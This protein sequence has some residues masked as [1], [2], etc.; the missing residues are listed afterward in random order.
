MSKDAERPRLDGSRVRLMQRDGVEVGVV[1]SFEHL[2]RRGCFRRLGRC[3]RL[4]TDMSTDHVGGPAFGLG[5][6]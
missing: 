5:V 3:D 2:G 6:G 4:A 1:L